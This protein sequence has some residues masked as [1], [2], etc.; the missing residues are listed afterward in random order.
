MTSVSR[1]SAKK[2]APHVKNPSRQ[3]EPPS[4]L[5]QNSKSSL[6]LTHAQLQRAP[7][8]NKNLHRI[9]EGNQSQQTLAGTRV[10]L[11]VCVAAQAGP[12]LSPSSVLLFYIGNHVN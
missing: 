6:S 3:S 12:A 7:V 9:T 2:T 4:A 5:Y 10:S 8:A 11:C 1:K